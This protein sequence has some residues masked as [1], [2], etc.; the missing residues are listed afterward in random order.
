[1]VAHKQKTRIL[2]DYR[3]KDQKCSQYAL[4]NL[5]FVV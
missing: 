2:L 5:P 4:Q 3:G 1:M